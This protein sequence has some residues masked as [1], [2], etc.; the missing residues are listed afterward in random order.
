MYRNLNKLFISVSLQVKSFIEIY[1]FLS[2]FN[3]ISVLSIHLLSVRLSIV[4][5]IIDYEL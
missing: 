3:Y 5:S 1:V 2:P 4:T